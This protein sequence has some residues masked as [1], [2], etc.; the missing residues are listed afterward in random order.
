MNIRE[1]AKQIFTKGTAL[2]FKDMEVYT[3]T[4][5]SF[6]ASVFNQETDKFSLS[7]NTGLSFR[8]V[9]MDG[10][11]GYSYTEKL[12][13]T[14]IEALVKSAFENAQYI[15]ADDVEEIAT[16]SSTEVKSFDYRTKI[17]DDMQTEV[18]LDMLR[19]LETHIKQLDSRIFSINYCMLGE[20]LDTTTIINT[21]GLNVEST[22]N[23]AYM[24][25]SVVA[26]QGDEVKTFSD[27]VL[28]EDILSVDYKAYGKHLVDEVI[29]Q[30]D[31]ISIDSGDYPTI[32]RSEMFA[33]LLNT[34][35][36]IFSAEK[37][38]QGISLLKDKIGEKI[39]A[40]IVTISDEPLLENSLIKTPFDAEGT[41]TYA[42][43][44]V[45]NGEFKL[46]LQN[47]KSAKKDDVKTT[48]NAT[49]RGFKDIPVVGFH[50][51]TLEPGYFTFNQLVETIDKGVLIT[52]LSGL[53]S[54][55]NLVSG[56]FSVEAGGYLIEDG[57][58]TSPIKQ[59]TI[60]GNF[61]EVLKNIDTIG[62]DCKMSLQSVY[63]PSVKVKK[64]AISD[65]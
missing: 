63:T 39:G 6:N 7:H 3:H 2:G 41:T 34:Y 8:G 46:F 32:I 50:C 44:V 59:M 47:N 18:K 45:E 14:S 5:S 61:V 38:Q 1:L 22:T 54:G 55:T 16:P 35:S 42:K 4:G 43:K 62:N 27:F 53:H 20:D 31:G 26:K 13:E 48:G 28:A 51:M 24:Y 29:A 65:K 36:S 33:S 57:K 40:S 10:K 52:S 58:I 12:D 21:K 49:K 25:L 23:V 37:A 17:S 9:N 15:E 56:D 64:L 19:K 30:F 11:M 60:A